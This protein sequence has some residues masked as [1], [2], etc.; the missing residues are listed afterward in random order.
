[1]GL[2]FSGLIINVSGGNL[3]AALFLTMIASL[4]L[5]M[6]LPTTPAYVIQAALAVPA[7]VNLG[8]PVIA[9]H[10][11]CLYFA[12][13]SAITPPVALA[14]YAGASISGGNAM[15]TGFIATR[16]GLAAYLVP[17]MFVYGPPLL[18][19]GQPLEVV[20]AVST[21]V[22]GV[23]GLAVAGEGWLLG[24]TFIWERGLCLVAALLL[25]KPGWKTDLIGLAIMSL[26]V[27]SQ[28]RRY[29]LGLKPTAEPA[30]E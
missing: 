28:M 9:A 27:L 10:L 24:R 22:L 3:L 1:L 29:G 17:Y 18:T 26:V 2:R 25:I 20:L 14:A 6:G 5:G 13:I 19:I 16:L 30:L 23:V 15:T 4:I 8:V 7:L 11:F 21:A 12:V